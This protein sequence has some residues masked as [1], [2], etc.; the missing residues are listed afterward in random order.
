MYT[1]DSLQESPSLTIDAGSANIAPAVSDKELVEWVVRQRRKAREDRADLERV[2]DECWDLFEGVSEEN[3]AKE[4]WQSD[5]VRPAAF[6]SVKQGVNAVRQFLRESEQPWFNEPVNPDDKASEIRG[7]RL[8]RLVKYQFESNQLFS[9]IAEGLES[10]F[11]TGVGIWRVGWGFRERR[12]PPQVEPQQLDPM[13]NPLGRRI[14]LTKVREGELNLRAVDPYNFY[15]LPGSKFNKWVGTIE[16]RQI[17]LHEAIALVKKVNKQN[18]GQPGFEPIDVAKIQGKRLDRVNKGTW[19]DRQHRDSDTVVLTEYWGPI[20]DKQHNIH[21]EQAHLL[22]LND[23]FLILRQANPFWFGTPPYVGFSPMHRPFRAAGIGVI[24]K[25]IQVDRAFD[26]LVNLAMDRELVALLFPFE[27]DRDALEN[28]EQLDAG[29]QPGAGYDIKQIAALQ[30]RQAIKPIQFSGGSP[31]VQVLAGLLDRAHQEGSQISE[32]VQGLPRFR[33]VQTATEIELKAG[34]QSGFLSALARDID[35]NAIK[36]LVE[37]AQD[38]TLQFIE[39]IGDTRVARILGQDIEV[40]AG[41]TKAERIEAVQCDCILKVEGVSGQVEKQ[42]MLQGLISFLGIISQGGDM[43]LP[44]INTRELL[45]RI[46]QAFRPAIRDVDKIFNPPEVEQAI[47]QQQQLMAALPALLGAQ[48]EVIKTA[49]Q[50]ETQN[51]TE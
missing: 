11:V 45:T 18:E 14:A 3:D 8:A 37:M 13:G 23:E 7:D 41:M 17:P 35:D 47:R 48:Q 5:V 36:P 22:I 6:A 19:T 51:G 33:G 40:F 42:E 9:A 28:P 25:A 43:W 16:D 27:V 31:Q 34:Q 15:W 12:L 38:M 30:G 26:R 24:E 46:G 1:T 4:D 2:W 20:L 10:S 50:T 32:I 21:H 44:A 39:T 49:A 29:L